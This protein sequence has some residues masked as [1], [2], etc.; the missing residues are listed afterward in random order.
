MVARAYRSILAEAHC[1]NATP[2]RKAPHANA[3]RFPRGSHSSF[4][5]N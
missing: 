2:I 3:M 5:R 4:R 1:T